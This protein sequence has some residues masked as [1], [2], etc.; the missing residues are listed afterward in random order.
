[1]TNTSKEDDDRED[2]L[3]DDEQNP[4]DNIEEEPA[5]ETANMPTELVSDLGAYWETDTSGGRN[6]TAYWIA[7]L[8]DCTFGDIKSQ[9]LDEKDRF[10]LLAMQT[11]YSSDA[12]HGGAI[13]AKRATKP[14]SHASNETLQ[15]G[16]NQGV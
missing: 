16:F 4:E 12:L 9:I 7:N 10:V 2:E 14:T 15:M 5:A 8:D 1:M 13:E 11:V 6:A 3:S